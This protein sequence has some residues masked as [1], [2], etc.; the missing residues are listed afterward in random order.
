MNNLTGTTKEWN[1]IVAE[2]LL[3]LENELRTT[4]SMLDQLANILATSNTLG[5]GGGGGGGKPFVTIA[6]QARAYIDLILTPEQKAIV[7]STKRD[8][9]ASM[10]R[11]K[12]ICELYKKGVSPNQIT[13]A[14]SKDHNSIYYHLAMAGLV[15]AKDNKQYSKR[16][17]SKALK[18]KRLMSPQNKE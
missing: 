9:N 17:A 6:E 15:K 14:L 5:G 18:M 13:I 3:N 2:R 8:Q 7:L 10:L 11:A 4:K 16:R 1:I 12:V